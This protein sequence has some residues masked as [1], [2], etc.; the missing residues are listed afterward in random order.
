MT[1]FEGK[2]S[3]FVIV[4]NINGKQVLSFVMSLQWNLGDS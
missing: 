4:D 2:V 1:T 3:G